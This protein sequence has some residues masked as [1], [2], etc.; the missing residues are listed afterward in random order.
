MSFSDILFERPSF[1]EGIA[2]IFDWFGG[3]NE[4]NESD[5]PADADHQ[6]MAADWYTVGDDL[7]NAIDH[8]SRDTVSGPRNQ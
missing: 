8:G 2:R 5:T 4:Y 3:L 7:R 1:T 6:A